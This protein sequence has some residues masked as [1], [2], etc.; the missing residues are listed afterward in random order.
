MREAFTHLREDYTEDDLTV[1][2]NHSGD[3]YAN[4]YT[5]YRNSYCYITGVPT[6][7][8]DYIYK[9]VGT[10]S[11]WQ[12]NYNHLKAWIDSQL[13]KESEATLDLDCF[14]IGDDIYL[15][16]TVNLEQDITNEWWVWMLVY[17]EM[18]DTYPLVV[19]GGDYTPTVLQIAGAGESD[20]YCWSFDPTGWDTEHL[21]GVCFLEKN[22]GDK[23]I[24]QSLML[25]LDLESLLDTH[26]PLV[27]DIDPEDGEDDV[28][29]DSTIEFTLRDD[30]GID[31]DTLNFTVTDD[32]LSSGRALTPGGRA[33]SVGFTRTGEISGELDIDDS[34]PQSVV[35][36]FTPDDEFGYEAT[37]TC[38]IAAGLEDGLGTPTSEDFVWSFITEEWVQV[39]ETSW[40]AIKAQF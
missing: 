3:S 18:W 14:A 16:T 33:L 8:V 32:T 36:T 15:E 24:V 35:C 26:E 37:I 23:E 25:H 22:H 21:V 38:T 2:S 20:S 1:V 5:N 11:T 4:S 28:A 30:S 6:A 9:Q 12:D 31:L 10:Y 13:T 40:G 27:E 17:Q 39:L 34:D 19:R 7:L 29:I